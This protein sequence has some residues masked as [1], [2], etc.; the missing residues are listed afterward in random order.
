MEATQTITADM[1]I[2]DVVRE[3]PNTIQVF[4]QYG[5]GCLGCALARFENIGQGAQA[6][7]I[8]VG[9]LIEDLNKAVPQPQVS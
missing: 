2:G 1:S 5:L 8:D 7:G 9:A 4:M 3:H 6:H